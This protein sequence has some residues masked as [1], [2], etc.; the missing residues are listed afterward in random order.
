[1]HGATLKKEVSR[2]LLLGNFSSCHNII[3][4]IHS[5]IFNL[6]HTSTPTYFG[7]EVPSS[8]R[9]YNRSM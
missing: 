7:A 9:H 3:Q 1:M 4:E 8:G 5:V 6:R 2:C